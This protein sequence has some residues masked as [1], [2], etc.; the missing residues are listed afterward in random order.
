[1]PTYKLHVKEAADHIRKKMPEPIRIGILSGTGLGESTSRLDV[2]EVINYR[3]IPN[4][5]RPTVESHAGK[6]VLGH[7]SGKAV[8]A[9]QG[10]FH[11]Y[12]GYSAKEVA[13]PVRV[14]Q[15]LGVR[16]L[17]LSNAAG[18]INP[19]FSPGE[20]MLLRDHLNLTGAN[21]LHG[22]NEDAWGLRFPDMSAVYDPLLTE[23]A[24]KAGDATGI[25]LKTGIYAGLMGPS[26][27]TPAE[28]RYLR[29]IGADAVGFSTVTEAIA[30]VHAGMRVLGLSVLTNVHNP[31]APAPS[32]IA[33]ILQVA[34]KAAPRVEQILGEVIGHIH[35]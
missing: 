17:L 4:F 34:G 25:P 24:L 29:A 10:R 6:L 9:F 2:S 32:S 7:W 35:V 33:E 22:P 12:E 21:P 18:G 16:V 1:M 19:S 15:E 3:E 14:M 28:V 26:L 23:K 5:P 20:I 30:A 8:M 11:L 27:E 31:D 13:F